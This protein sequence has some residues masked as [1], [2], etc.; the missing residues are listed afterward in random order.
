M[1]LNFDFF[2]SND[3]FNIVSWDRDQ[4][5]RIHTMDVD[6]FRS[7]DQQDKALVG[8]TGGGSRKAATAAGVDDK[9]NGEDVGNLLS[10]AAGAGRTGQQ[11]GA[12]QLCTNT[13]NSSRKSSFSEYTCGT[14]P[15]TNLQCLINNNN[16]NNKTLGNAERET[17]VNVN[18]D[19]VESHFVKSSFTNSISIGNSHNLL[20]SSSST[21]SAHEFLKKYPKC[22]GAKF[23]GLPG[24]F[25]DFLV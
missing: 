13:S 8:G 10:N 19:Q 16:N 21:L 15:T 4:R 2:I 1:I 22:F 3:T 9:E 17:S 6:Q 11:S 18:D 7:K 14:P 5:I 12:L 20:K 23:T 24:I 25:G